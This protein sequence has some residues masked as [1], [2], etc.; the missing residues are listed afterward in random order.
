MTEI[1]TGRSAPPQGGAE[2]LDWIFQSNAQ[3]TP[4]ALALV[5][6]PDRAQFSGVAPRRLSYAEA[7][8][9]IERLANR[10][11]QLGLPRGASV[12]LL[13]ANTVETVVTLL[14]VQ[15]AGLTA[16]LLPLAL[17]ADRMAAA[18]AAVG[19]RALATCDG[20][21][22]GERLCDVAV[23]LAAETFSI[24]YVCGFGAELPDGVVGLDDV[25]DGRTDDDAIVTFDS[26]SGALV[27][28]ATMPDGSAHPVMR[29]TAELLVGGLAV[30]VEAEMPRGAT[31]VGTMLLSSFAAASCTLAPW[32]LTGGTL[33]L[34]QP[35]AADALAQQMRMHDGDML[36]APGPAA[37]E[38]FAACGANRPR[39]LLAVWRAPEQQT[40]AVAWPHDASFVDVLAFGETGVIALRRD[41]SG[42]PRTIP[43]GAVKA[44]TY[45]AK[46]TLVLTTA[47]TEDGT[48]ALS[49]PMAPASDPVRDGG[50]A[51]RRTADTRYPCEFDAA[52]NAFRL[53]GGPIAP[54]RR[55]VEPDGPE[56][57]A[58][59]A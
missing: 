14:A 50:S 30:V 40:N 37:A 55:G 48:L 31:I 17:R 18:L 4:D 22:G 5:D 25:F 51:P 12:A 45:A 39:R 3:R 41:A 38:I 42:A 6:P 52:E 16:A 13:L 27:T 49:G 33:A 59:A 57:Q 58:P 44:P 29:Q 8:A 46:G 19:A 21:P 10:L 28:F 34:H 56:L 26:C 9:A 24:R 15:R 53:T 47:R 1:A 2:S 35:F 36:V 54:A 11:G 43:A 32:L 23:Q 20:R 7:D